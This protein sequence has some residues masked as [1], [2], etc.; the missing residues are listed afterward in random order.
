[1]Q[2]KISKM[3]LPNSDEQPP[4]SRTIRIQE[5]DDCP[6]LNERRASLAMI[7]RRLDMQRFSF[8]ATGLELEEQPASGPAMARSGGLDAGLYIEWRRADC[9]A[10]SC[11]SMLGNWLGVSS[12][13]CPLSV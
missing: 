10:V 9:K 12:A 8:S 6:A 5:A 11:R 7:E 1:M 2:S 4:R 3:Y 13:C